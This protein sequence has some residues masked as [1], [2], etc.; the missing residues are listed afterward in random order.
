LAQVPVPQGERSMMPVQVEGFIPV[1]FACGDGDDVFAMCLR[2]HRRRRELTN[3]RTCDLR[4]LRMY[5]R[6]LLCRGGF[7]HLGDA[8]DVSAFIGRELQAELRG[9]CN[10]VEH[11][12]PSHVHFDSAKCGDFY[13]EIEMHGKS[14]DVLECDL[15]DL[16]IFALGADADQPGWRFKHELG[17]GFHHWN[18]ACLEQCRRYADGIRARH[19]RVLGLL[20]DDETRG[21]F[22]MRRRHNDVAAQGGVSARFTQHAQ[23]QVIQIFLHVFHFFEHGLAGHVEHATGDDATRFAAGMKVNGGD[24]V[25]EVHEF[26]PWKVA[27]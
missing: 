14:R 11:A 12:A 20:H 3:R 15:R 25:G 19:G 26:T 13:V 4:V 17:D 24:E 5:D 1:Y 27:D 9:I 21:G 2:M 22:G 18:H 10:G 6:V 7:D 16:A 8:G 23:T